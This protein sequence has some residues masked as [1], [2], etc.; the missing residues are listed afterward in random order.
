MDEDLLTHQDRKRQARR[1]IGGSLRKAR[2][3]EDIQGKTRTI[4][5]YG[6]VVQHMWKN[7]ALT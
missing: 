4:G 6:G 3:G 2:G 1:V 5:G 7:L